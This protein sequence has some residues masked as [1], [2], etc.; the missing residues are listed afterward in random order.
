MITEHFLA[1]GYV[2]KYSVVSI[3]RFDNTC[4]QAFWPDTQYISNVIGLALNQGG[5]GADIEVCIIGKVTDPTFN[6]TIK[7]NVY[8]G[9]GGYLTQTIP[10]KSVYIIGKAIAKNSILVSLSQP[11]ILKH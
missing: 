10:D 9:I 3:G 2:S 1:D 5:D 7:K 6:F 8:I 4:T 11:F